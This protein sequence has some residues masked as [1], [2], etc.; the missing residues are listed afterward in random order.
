MESNFRLCC[1]K[2]RKQ[3]SHR[4]HILRHHGTILSNRKA[5]VCINCR[6][7]FSDESEFTLHRNICKSFIKPK[8]YA[9]LT[10]ITDRKFIFSNNKET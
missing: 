10:K 6:F 1:G 7:N 9:K 8:R 5:Y 3:T 2:H 4:E